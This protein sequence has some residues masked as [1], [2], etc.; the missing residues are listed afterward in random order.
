[1][2]ALVAPALASSPPAAVAFIPGVD[3]NLYR[4]VVF[5]VGKNFKFRRGGQSLR[6]VSSLGCRQ[7]FHGLPRGL[8]R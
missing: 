2:S 8:G 4:L 6:R 1:M 7:I 3:I 5:V